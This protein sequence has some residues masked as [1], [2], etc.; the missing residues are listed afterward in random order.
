MWELFCN[1]EVTK[2]EVEIQH[3]KGGGVEDGRTSLS[4]SINSGPLICGFLS[5]KPQTST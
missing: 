3:T 4:Y 2:H 5:Q 1:L